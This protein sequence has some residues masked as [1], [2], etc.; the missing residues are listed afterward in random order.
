MR[1]QLKCGSEERRQAIRDSTLNAIDYLEVLPRTETVPR[2]LL[3][4]FCFKPEF[5]SELQEDNNVLIEGGVRIRDLGVAWMQVA[6][7]VIENLGDVG[8]V[9]TNDLADE[10]KI[11]IQKIEE[12][13]RD[14]ILIIRPTRD[15]DF[16]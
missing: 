2:P 7:T 10:E 3:L 12:R 4:L 8:N 13:D 15:G 9:V 6:D 11:A 5:L 1:I 14:R 16:S